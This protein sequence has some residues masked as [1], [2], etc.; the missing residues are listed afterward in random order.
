MKKLILVM[1]AI[2][3]TA[4]AQQSVPAPIPS[5]NPQVVEIRLAQPPAVNPAVPSSV[6]EFVKGS[7]DLG[8]AIGGGL[9]NLAHEAKDM[10]FGKDKTLVEGLDDLS[11]TNAGKFTMAVIAWKVAGKDA[12]DLLDRVKRVFIGVPL[13]IAWNALLLW[14]WRRNFLTY[15]VLTS[16]EGPWYARKKT[17]QLANV[18]D[19]WGEGKCA[20]AVITALVW[21]AT[22]VSILVSIVF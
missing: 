10:T 18:D 14:F 7:Q 20:A 4:F 8:T 13:L 2:T 9:K 1:L 15:R 12:L 16:V 19:N 5:P 11:K 22:T 3:A 21:A 6:S 17:Y